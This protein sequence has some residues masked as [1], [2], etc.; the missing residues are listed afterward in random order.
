MLC[1]AEKYRFTYKNRE[2]EVFLVF[3]NNVFLW[4]NDKGVEFNPDIQVILFDIQF[5]STYFK[6]IHVNRYSY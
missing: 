1:Y 5:Y 2:K 6:V 3:K 4:V